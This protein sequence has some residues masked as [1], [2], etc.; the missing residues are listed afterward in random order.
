MVEVGV[1]EI[2]VV[3]VGA[4][5]VGVAG[6]GAAEGFEH[7]VRIMFQRLFSSSEHRRE[8]RAETAF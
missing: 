1:A 2:G 4:V 5:E 8:D 6:V 7:I 3:E